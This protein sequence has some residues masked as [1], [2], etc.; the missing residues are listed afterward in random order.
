MGQSQQLKH[1]T[2]NER[3]PSSNIYR[4][5]Q[6]SKGYLWVCTDKGIARYNGYEFR[7]FTIKDGLFYNDIWD[8]FEDS[9]GRLWLNS[10]D[11]HFCYIQDEKVYC[12]EN[13]IEE[14]ESSFGNITSYYEHENGEIWM[15]ASPRRVIK[16]KTDNFI[17]CF[18]IKGSAYSTINNNIVEYAYLKNAEHSEDFTKLLFNL[19]P[20]IEKTTFGIAKDSLITL[21]PKPAKRPILETQNQRVEEDMVATQIIAELKSKYPNLI[22]TAVRY[23]NEIF[24]NMDGLVFFTINENHEIHDSITILFNKSRQV[25]SYPLPAPIQPIGS[26]DYHVTSPKSI[27]FYEQY[28]AAFD[29][30]FRWNGFLVE[31]WLQGKKIAGKKSLY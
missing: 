16:I 25:K 7:V 30:L 2:L 18:Q 24:N 12:I 20:I 1:F 27:I 23:G 5:F 29:T 15:F 3:L 19:A 10:F 26:F 6:D 31:K 9:Q 14:C 8:C 13:D 21:A 22:K 17:E 4:T 28:T 11:S